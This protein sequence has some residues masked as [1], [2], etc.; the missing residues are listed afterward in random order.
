MKKD[1]IIT[2]R[3]L[4]QYEDSDAD[5]IELVTEGRFYRKGETYYATYRESA[6]TGLGDTTTTMKFEPNRVTVVRFGDTHTHL[7]FEEGQKHLSYYDTGFGSL[8]VGVSTQ[9]IRKS[10]SP[11]GG[12]VEVD[13]SME[14][15]HAL[16]G[17]NAFRV[18][19]READ[20]IRN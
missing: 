9:Q 19:I 3:G 18:Q 1:V 8:T 20:T 14:I 10:L 4:Q 5:R 12:Q 7:V 15:N 6:L 13:Y 16:A 17:E 2:I 11:C